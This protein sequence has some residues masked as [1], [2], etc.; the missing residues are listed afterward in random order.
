MLDQGGAVDTYT[1]PTTGVPIDFGVSV[2]IDHGDATSFVER[3]NIT[4][5]PPSAPGAPGITKR[6]DFTTGEELRTYVGP[7]PANATAALDAY[8][9]EAEK[10]EDL[11]TTGRSGEGDNG[12]AI[13]E[14]LLLP[15]ADFVGKY[16]IE[17]A[18]PALFASTGLGV[19]RP[20]DE[21]TITVMQ[22]FGAQMARSMLGQQASFVPASRRN[23]DVYDAIATLLGA[24][25]VLYETTVVN[26]TRTDE[27][28]VVTARSLTDGSLTTVIRASRLL[29]A[30]P[31]LPEV[32][33]AETLDLDETETALFAQWRYSRVHAALVRNAEDPGTNSTASF[34]V[35]NRPL[36][37]QPRNYLDTPARPFVDRF[38]RVGADAAGRDVFRV[39]VVGDETLGGREA[40]DLV[41]ATF[42]TLVR[43]GAFDR[44][45]TKAEAEEDLEF[46]AFSDHGPMHLRA[47]A[48]AYRAGFLRDL[49]ALQGRR[50]TWYTGGAWATNF[51]TTLWGFNEI[52]LPRM[53]AG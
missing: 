10:Y 52:L 32:L 38:R 45:M 39:I 16:S 37:S 26:A 8:R 41:R 27:G 13:L 40:Q 23:Q 6:F 47:S 4:M 2:F 29:V 46:V 7:D 3:L 21:L 44:Q 18:V 36:A 49:H 30:V 51:Q 33:G 50:S 28:V 12:T 20:A 11:L 25:D 1:D 42:G 17:A 9:V 34:S 35:E 15:F 24:D 31:P 5:A 19:G 22:A 53:L 14:D 48:D 43:N